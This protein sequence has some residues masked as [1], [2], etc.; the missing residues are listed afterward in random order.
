MMASRKSKEKADWEKR[1]VNL[2]GKIWICG[3][4]I[5]EKVGLFGKK[6]RAVLRPS[7]FKLYC[8]CGY[9]VGESALRIM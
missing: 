3:G 5:W 7:L 8:G 4:S 6:S 9:P 1:L 2:F